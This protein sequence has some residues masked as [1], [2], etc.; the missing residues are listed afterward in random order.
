MK[1]TIGKR[2]FDARTNAGMTQRE[3]SEKSGYSINHIS[4]IERDVYTPSTRALIAF[5]RALRTKLVK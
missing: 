5:E 4:Q 1:K 3:L 2:L